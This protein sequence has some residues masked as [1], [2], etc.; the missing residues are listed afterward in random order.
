MVQLNKECC[1]HK[2]FQAEQLLPL[3]NIR[4]HPC[5][6][7]IL[8]WEIVGNC[9]TTSLLE[10]TSFDAISTDTSP[11]LGCSKLIPGPREKVQ[12]PQCVLQ[13]F[14]SSLLGCSLVVCISTHRGGAQG[15]A[16]AGRGGGGLRGAQPAVQ[17]Q[18]QRCQRPQRAQHRRLPLR[19]CPGPRWP[20][21]CFAAANPFFRTE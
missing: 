4:I 11:L 17:L 10:E 20:P 15:E 12:A 3:F 8:F 6:F 7:R 19:P 1:C 5:S 21:C 16:S 2:V 13:A 14:G 9:L 18:G